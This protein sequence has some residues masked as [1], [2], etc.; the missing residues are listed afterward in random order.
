MAESFSNG[1]YTDS[2]VG[3]PLQSTGGLFIPEIWTS[4]LLADLEANLILGSSMITNRA[5]DGEFRRGGDVVRIPHFVD[6]VEDYGS[7]NAYDTFQPSEMDRAELEYIKMTVAKG[8]SFR[9]EVDSLHQLQTQAGIDLM[10]GLVSQRARKTAQAVDRLVAQTILGAVLGKDLNG[11]TSA[12]VPTVL[13]EF[14]ALPALHGTVAQKTIPGSGDNRIYN[15]IVDMMAELDLNAAPQDRYLVI[16]PNV[17]AELLKTPEFINASHWGAGSVMATGQIG[18]ILGVPVFVS[19]ALANT[20]PNRTKKLVAPVHDGAAK[21]QMV[22]GST[23]AVSLVIPHAEMMAYNP[24]NSF[25]S[26]VKSRVVYD[27]KVIRPEQLVVASDAAIEPPS[28]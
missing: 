7:K 25:T 24:E 28:S 8:S 13:A 3:H 16:A 27:A 17:R 15:T 26:A 10:S 14:N 2:A 19:N 18:Q 4:Q 23:N 6:T 12:S 21:F 11:S 20:N 22:L 9:F 1:V 5:Y